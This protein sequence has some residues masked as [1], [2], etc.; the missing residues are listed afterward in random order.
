VTA[1]RSS[2]RDV[3]NPILALPAVAAIDALPPEA[4]A[5]LR[6]VM[7]DLKADARVRADAAWRKH[8]GPM[9]AYWKAASV[10]AGHIAKVL[11]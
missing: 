1:A 6:Q 3:R 5:A 7:L 9:A 10:Y 8:K 4:K 2:R 11:K